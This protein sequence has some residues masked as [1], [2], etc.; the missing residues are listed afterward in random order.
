M[1]KYTALFFVFA[2]LISACSALEDLSGVTFEDATATAP[3]PTATVE[4]IS[5][6]TPDDLA[7]MGALGTAIRATMNVEQSTPMPEPTATKVLTAT[8]ALTAT[9]TLTET[10]ELNEPLEMT[11]DEF[12]SKVRYDDRFP[13]N[14]MIW[15]QSYFEGEIFVANMFSAHD[16]TFKSQKG[17]VVVYFL[18]AQGGGRI[19]FTGWDGM[20]FELDSDSGVTLGQAVAA[21]R[22]T[23]VEAHGCK[24]EKIQYHE[25]FRHGDPVK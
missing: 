1:K 21:M 4:M 16:H 11:L 9:T 2:L 15:D 24:P 6:P 5:T 14:G 19:R 3:A 7:T 8:A 22:E 17:C 23:L 13:L 10:V 20:G 25:L 12:G 18:A